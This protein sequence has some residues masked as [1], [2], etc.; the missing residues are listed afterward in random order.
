MQ[1]L[2]EHS[3][4]K[5]KQPKLV[6]VGK[7]ESTNK[8]DFFKNALEVIELEKNHTDLQQKHE[9]THQDLMA[10]LERVQAIKSFGKTRLQLEMGIKEFKA[11]QENYQKQ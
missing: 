8:D 6:E 5:A 7:G 3:P 1:L 9:R 2:F 10:F 4:K 11:L